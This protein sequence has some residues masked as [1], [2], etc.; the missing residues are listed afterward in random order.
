[1]QGVG[2]RMLDAML[3]ALAAWARRSRVG[4]VLLAVAALIAAAIDWRLG[5]ATVVAVFTASV[6][7]LAVRASW[8][9]LGAL[10]RAALGVAALGAVTAAVLLP[11]LL[12]DEIPLFGLDPIWLWPFDAIPA[13]PVDAIE[14]WH[15]AVVAAA[16]AGV[17]AGLL[18]AP[19]VAA[20]SWSRGPG[21]L[22]LRVAFL[23]GL[24]LTGAAST[25]LGAGYGAWITAYSVVGVGRLLVALLFGGA[26]LGLAVLSWKLI[27]GRAWRRMERMDGARRQ[28]LLAVSVACLVPLLA[29]AGAALPVLFFFDL[30]PRVDALAGLLATTGWIVV[31]AAAVIGACVLVPAAVAIGWR[32]LAGSTPPDRRLMAGLSVATVAAVAGLLAFALPNILDLAGP[33]GLGG[34]GS[35]Y[36]VEVR[37]T[38]GD[39]NL[40]DLTMLAAFPGEAPDVVRVDR[41]QVRGTLGSGYLARS[42][43]IPGPQRYGSVTFTDVLGRSVHEPLCTGARCPSVEVR[44]V[45]FP[46]GVI[47]QVAHGRIDQR[48]PF[49]RTELVEA[50]VTSIAGGGDVVFSYVPEPLNVLPAA[51]LDHL[52]EL[53]S[54]QQLA[55]LLLVGAGMLVVKGTGDVAV[56]WAVRRFERRSGRLRD[57]L[58]GSGAPYAPAP[59]PPPPPAPRLRRGGHPVRGRPPDDG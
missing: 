1:M 15:D 33:H 9:P 19:R 51:V 56:G 53:P 14:R 28:P 29:G 27:I 43:V 25:L 48:E 23:A 12:L 6:A 32:A 35:F 39:P 20:A 37:P 22:D 3:P 7:W 10:P 41:T 8:R 4:L 30:Q 59:H 54:I 45:D 5:I 46:K 16:A 11:T 55:V 13:Y 24:V 2:V 18:V 58:L 42:A 21:R 57:P 38:P 47:Y 50:S 52:T 44:F 17:A 49:G 36:T 40:F 34:G 31:T 26:G